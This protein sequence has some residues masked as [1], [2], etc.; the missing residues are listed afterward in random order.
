MSDVVRPCVMKCPQFGGFLG[1]IASAR[2]TGCPQCP[3]KSRV[4]YSDAEYFNQ[5]AKDASIG[6]AQRNSPYPTLAQYRDAF[7]R[8]LGGTAIA[9]RNKALFAFMMI[10][11]ARDGAISSCRLKHV[12][13]IEGTV[14]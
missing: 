2:K 4:S 14:F 9:R 1:G 12:D 10:T 5:N 6:H 7:D 13:L 3:Y 11:G 8:M